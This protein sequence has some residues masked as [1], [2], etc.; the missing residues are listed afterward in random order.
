MREGRGTFDQVHRFGLLGT[1][2]VLVQGCI[3]GEMKARHAET[4][5][6]GDC[7]CRGSPWDGVAPRLHVA[8]HLPI[9]A[10]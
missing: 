8:T 7:G 1:L 2:G 6:L 3:F 5:R 10:V 9:A 4:K